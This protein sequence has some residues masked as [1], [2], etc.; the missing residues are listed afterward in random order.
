MTRPESG[1]ACGYDCFGRCTQLYQPVFHRERQH[2]LCMCRTHW[3]HCNL[4]QPKATYGLLQS[5]STL[6]VNSLV[7]NNS[8]VALA[9]AA[10]S[11]FYCLGLAE[12]A[13]GQH[14]LTTPCPQSSSSP[15]SWCHARQAA[16]VPASMGTQRVGQCMFQSKPFLQVHAWLHLRLR[17]KSC[18]VCNCTCC[19][20]STK[21]HSCFHVDGNS[22]LHQTC[23][24]VQ[25][26]I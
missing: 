2:E 13:P 17:S 23:A 8:A 12:L 26:F 21:Q 25:L 10:A 1:T 16:P 9:I 11:P 3:I 5:V 4:H 6:L 14:Q 24:Q 15:A 18:T 19:M 20:S 22:P 7:R